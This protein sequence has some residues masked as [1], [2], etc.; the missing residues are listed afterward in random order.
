[1]RLSAIPF[2]VKELGTAA[3]VFI[4]F[5]LM[6][7]GT[8]NLRLSSGTAVKTDQPVQLYI[9][10]NIN[11]EQLAVL[12]NEKGIKYKEKELKWAGALL[13]WRN[14]KRG[15]YQLKDGYSYESFFSK[16]ALGIQDP[17]RLTILPG[18]TPERFARSAAA[19]LKADSLAFI[20]VFNDSLYLHK[21]GFTREQLF[22]RML[23][24]TYDIYWTSEPETVINRIL[25]HF[26][27]QVTRPLSKSAEESGRTL[28]EILTMAS[29]V[30]WE[31]TKPEEKPVISGLYW[32]RIKRNMPLQADPTV[33]F[34]V[35]ER[36]RLL[37]EDYKTEHPF[38]TYIH[39]GLPPAPI[40]NPALSTIKAT[41]MPQQHDYLYMVANPEGGHV[42]TRTFRE[43]TIESEKWRRWL[44]EQYRIKR[45]REA[46][47]AREIPGGN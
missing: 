46:E 2:T 14:F 42:F 5:L 39:S 24:D 21:K 45:Q 31:A 25:N 4:F 28:D 6:V 7:N 17:V 30:E 34:A 20:E 23:P 38:N 26:D 8:R 47:A 32:N 1:M 9:D 15:H 18:I 22:G 44:Q 36:R 33:N 11:L 43:H 35:G 37:F 16:L 40:T 3:I 13:G 29:I 10:D 19:R 27:E 41:L 12:M